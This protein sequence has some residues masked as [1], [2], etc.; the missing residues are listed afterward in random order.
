MLQYTSSITQI[1]HLSHLF[2]HIRHQIPTNMPRASYTAFQRHLLFFSTPTQP[3]RL[4]FLSALRAATRIGLD[5]PVAIILSLSLRLMYAPFPNF[6]SSINIED[7]PRSQH[8]T[9]LE[10]VALPPSTSTSKSEEGYTCSELLTLLNSV[11]S[12]KKM[13]IIEK[14]INQGHIIGFWAMAASTKTHRV[15]KEDV[16]R[17]QLGEW[18]EDVAKR[19]RGRNDVLPLWRGGPIWVA[20]H[21]WAVRRLLGVRVYGKD[22]K[23]E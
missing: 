23:V 7:I 3:P 4:T 5:M 15:S 12:T 17:F 13:G 14:S 22:G 20:G 9:Q 19:R 11:D 2:S 10:N 18:E 21:S 6:F 1:P 16:E 8:R